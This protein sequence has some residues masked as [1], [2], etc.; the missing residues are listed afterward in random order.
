MTVT[1]IITLITNYND[2]DDDT[3]RRGEERRGRGEE[4]R[5]EGWVVTMRRVMEWK[6]KGMVWYGY[7]IYT[8]MTSIGTHAE[9]QQTLLSKNLINKKH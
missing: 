7:G 8:L 6:V 5:G 1:M 4:R 3:E 2:Y 9:N